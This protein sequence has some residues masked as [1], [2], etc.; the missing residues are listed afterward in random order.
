MDDF[1]VVTIKN[2]SK[3][4][5]E[6]VYNNSLTKTIPAGMAMRMP[7]NPLGMLAHKHLIDR[8]CN[9]YNE[10]SGDPAIRAK[11]SSEIL[12]DDANNLDEAPLNPNQALQRKLDLLNHTNES[13]SVKIC[14]TCG[15]KTFSLPE[16]NALNHEP[17]M[18]DAIR[19]EAEEEKK[20]RE[21]LL[22]QNEK[23]LANAVGGKEH[24]ELPEVDL[25]KPEVPAF[26]VKQKELT[27]EALIAFA[28]DVQKMNVEDKT[29]KEFLETQPLDRIAQEIGYNL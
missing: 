2:P 22:K 6:L 5:F 23:I 7:W 10:S 9:E 11:W 17:N 8:M 3:E 12:I 4:P 18:A 13:E 25:T 29:T 28:R 16:H 24:T 15:I 21:D 19:K 26:P 1:R 27:R 14:E 20:Q